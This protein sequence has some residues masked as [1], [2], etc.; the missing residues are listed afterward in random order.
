MLAQR[1]P[2]EA[3]RR[4]DFDARV[5]VADP[6]QLVTLCYEQFIAALGSALIAH[7]RADNQLKSQAM[8]RAL[9]ALMALQMGVSETEGVAKALVQLY[10]AARRSLLDNVL[11]FDPRVVATIRQ[12]F[13][14]IARAM[15]GSASGGMSGS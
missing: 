1:N 13:M 15:N 5:S 11:H 12:D 9:S 3:Y 8:T 6:K 14:D 2:Q 7:E 10:G 4:V